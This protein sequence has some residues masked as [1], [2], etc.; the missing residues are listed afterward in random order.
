MGDEQDAQE[1]EIID[2]LERELRIGCSARSIIY[3]S[4][5]CASPCRPARTDRGAE[6]LS[7]RNCRSRSSRS[8]CTDARTDTHWRQYPHHS[9][10]TRTRRPRAHPP[11]RPKHTPRARRAP[12]FS[13]RC[14]R[15]CSARTL[16]SCCLP[17]STRTSFSWTTTARGGT[18]RTASVR[19]PGRYPPRVRARLAALL[20]GAARWAHAAEQGYLLNRMSW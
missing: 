9:P 11:H 16:H 10:A 3:S 14:A 5:E 8:S 12:C 18:S 6:R 2:E 19:E 1:D 20:P 4:R 17:R 13:S 7:R 15:A